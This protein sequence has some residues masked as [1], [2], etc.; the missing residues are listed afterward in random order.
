MEYQCI[1][2]SEPDPAFRKENDAAIRVAATYMA[3]RV[4]SVAALWLFTGDLV[5]VLLFPQLVYALFDAK[6]N[7]TGSIVAF[8]VSLALRL[9]GGVSLETNSGQMGFP[10]LLHLPEWIPGV[11]PGSASDWYDSIGA[12]TYP[13][14]TLA[15]AAGMILLPLVSRM[16]GRWDPPRSLRKQA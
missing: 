6:A 16:T 9:G 8:A 7:R 14:R 1:E 3:M 13:V 12:A 10:A 15:A 11:L 4:Q 5:F 2:R